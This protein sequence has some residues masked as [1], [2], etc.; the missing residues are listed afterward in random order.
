MDTLRRGLA[1]YEVVIEDGATNRGVLL[2]LL[3]RPDVRGRHR[4]HRM[5]R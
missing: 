2:D 4:D 1:E 3:G 5:A